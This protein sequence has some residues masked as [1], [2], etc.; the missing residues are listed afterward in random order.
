VPEEAVPNAPRVVIISHRFW[1]ERFGGAKS[2]LDQQL[3][4]VGRVAPSRRV[5]PAAS[6]RS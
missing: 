1:Q 3:D 6:G 2:A 4:A 5:M